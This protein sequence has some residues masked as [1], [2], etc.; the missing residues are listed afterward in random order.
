MMASIYD[1][2][3]VNSGSTQTIGAGVTASDVTVDTATQIVASGGTTINTRLVNTSIIPFPHLSTQIVQGG[4]VAIGTQ[5]LGA[6]ITGGGPYLNPA[7]STQIVLAGG[8]VSDTLI[9]GDSSGYEGTLGSLGRYFEVLSPATQVLNAGA[10]ASNDIINADATVTVS[11]GADLSGA[12][13]TGVV[14]NWQLWEPGIGNV[15]SSHTSLAEADIETG[16]IASHL[17]INEDGLAR[18]AAGAIVSDVTLNGGT[19]ELASGAA[20]PVLLNITDGILQIDDLAYNLGHM[21]LTRD[22]A[23]GLLVS[24]GITTRDI[25]VSSMTSDIVLRLQAAATGSGTDIVLGD[26]TVPCFCPGTLIATETGDRPIEDLKIG[27]LLLTASGDLRPLRWIGRRAYGALFARGNR[28][29]MPVCIAR[30]ALGG[31]LPRRD[32]RVS[33][34]HAM[35]V[36]GVLVPAL[37]LVNGGSIRQVEITGDLSYLHLELED[38]D[39]LLAEG[40]PTE[41]FIDDNSRNLFHNAA[42]YHALYPG[43]P[44]RSPRF[45]LP[46]IEEG[47]EL[48]AIHTRLAAAGDGTCT[49]DVVGPHTIEGWIA[50]TSAPMSIVIMV[51]GA[52]I[53]RCRTD[54]LRPDVAAHYGVERAYGFVFGLPAAMRDLTPER[55]SVRPLGHSPLQHVA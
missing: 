29:I 2:T 32:L 25:P 20:A 52:V 13:L 36:D 15:A 34:M 8:Q 5:V 27:D 4:G 11:T 16:A 43:A 10:T 9:Q 24:N 44:A 54:R 42:E 53:G 12:T 7:S 38:H 35:V 47:P 14:H 26:V 46:R 22:P 48:L 40:A 18:V 1:N 17:T 49:L 3:T 23:G 30:G 21:T 41:S 37:H 28:D 55:V 19:L 51:D 33:P 31:D 50:G 45:C 39:I 6:P